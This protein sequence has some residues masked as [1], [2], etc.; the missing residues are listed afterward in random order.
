MSIFIFLGIILKPLITFSSY[1]CKLLGEK[2]KSPF[3]ELS[4]AMSF[5]IVICKGLMILIK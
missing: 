2:E 4:I 3:A 1:L 5:I